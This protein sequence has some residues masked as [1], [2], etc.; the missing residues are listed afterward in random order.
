MS[1]VPASNQ[2]MTLKQAA[3]QLQVNLRTIQRYISDGKLK[4]IRIT[5]KNTRI[6]PR[7]WE[8]FL[9]AGRS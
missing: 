5:R 3:E 6:A 7:D 2:L 8:Q 9:R 4:V 1:A